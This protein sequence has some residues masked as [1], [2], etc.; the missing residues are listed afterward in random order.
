MITVQL[1]SASAARATCDSIVRNEPHVAERTDSFSEPCDPVEDWAVHGATL[2]LVWSLT[3]EVTFTC[4]CVAGARPYLLREDDLR[5]GSKPWLLSISARYRKL[6][7]NHWASRLSIL[8][9]VAGR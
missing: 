2:T 5:D 1:I 6:A 9:A 4:S 3:H 7:Q 8:V